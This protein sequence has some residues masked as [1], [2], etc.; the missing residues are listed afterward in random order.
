MRPQPVSMYRSS[1]NRRRCIVARRQDALET[2]RQE[3]ISL[4]LS[5]DRILLVA[6]SV[7]SVEDLVRVRKEVTKG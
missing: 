3:C 4:G 2:V 7:T 5:S 6:G 1:L